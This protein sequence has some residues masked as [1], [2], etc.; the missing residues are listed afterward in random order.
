M[1]TAARHVETRVS[2]QRIPN[3][4][5]TGLLILILI[6]LAPLAWAA[7]ITVPNGDF[8]DPDNDGQIGGLLGTNIVNQPIGSGPW[9]GTS[10]GVAGLLARPV[11]SIDS[12]SQSATISGLLGINLAGL[13]NNAGYFQQQLSESYQ[14]GR[15]YILSA[16]IDAGTA[17]T[18][19]LL[20]DVNVGI[21]LTAGGNLIAAS[22][23]A[24]PQ[25]IELDLVSDDTYRL[26]FGHVADIAASGFI[27]LRLFNQPT[28]LLTASLFESVTFANVELEGRDIG[29]PT[30]I[31]VDSGDDPNQAETGQPFPGQFI[32]IIEDDDGDGVPGFAV[33]I[34]APLDGASA[35]VDSPT[36][37]DPPGP[38]IIATTDLDGIATFN[39][40]ANEIAGC[41]RILVEPLDPKMEMEPAVFYM[42]N[43][44]DDPSQNSIFCNGFEQ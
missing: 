27:G 13:L 7:P 4:P 29:P 5:R 14:F 30:A 32:I 36:S 18:L 15:F 33:R 39:A 24:D 19:G 42:R 8:S 35:D 31:V 17:L 40:T 1:N 26:R 6:L 11:L 22:T 41:Y 2:S 37:S 21:G 28:G 38:V 34:S 16:D 20:D 43:W 10:L 3:R 44:S 12:A 23:L 25:L 9:H